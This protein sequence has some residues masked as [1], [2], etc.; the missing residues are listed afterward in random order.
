LIQPAGRPRG[1]A[2]A[3]AAAAAL[4]FGGCGAAAPTSGPPSPTA[5]P[6][7]YYTEADSGQTVHLFVG[8][9]AGLR[10]SDHYTWSDPRSSGALLRVARAT[11]PP[12]AG[13]HEWTITGVGRGTAAVTSAGRI[14]C[15]PGAVCPGAILAFRLT[16]LVA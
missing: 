8:E 3:L 10:L 13:Y 2:A 7:V 4:L 6:S 16:V 5:S 12:A 9:V 1:A 11:G 14:A 15:S